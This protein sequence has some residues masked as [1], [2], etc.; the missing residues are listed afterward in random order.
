MRGIGAIAD[1]IVVSFP[2][3]SRSLKVPRP[4]SVVTPILAAILLCVTPVSGAAANAYLP[5][6]HEL[7]QGV[8]GQ[9]ISAY[10]Q[11]TGKHPAI[12]QV[13]SAWG[14]WLPAIFADAHAA[15]ARLMIHMTSASGSSEVITPGQI[16]RGDG[17]GWL[18]ALNQEIAATHTITYVRWMAEMDAYWNPYS[19]FNADGS[20]RDADHSTAAYRAA[21]RRAAL[22]LRG[23]ALTS[24]N[25]SLRAL[26]QPAVRG[27]HA[28]LPVAPV[29]MVWCPQVAGA[30]D[31][32]GN[33][34]SDYFPGRRWVDWMG[35]DFYSKF[36][37][38]TGLTRFYTAFRGLPFAFGEWSMWGA[39]NP[40]FVDQ[41]FRWVGAHSRVRMLVYNQGWGGEPFE[42]RLYP[43]AAA[44][45]RAWLWGGRW[46]GFV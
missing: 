28:A 4:A 5:P 3:L 38:F 36:P 39:D 19:A 40:G 35:T 37:N 27:V 13:F 22:I 33:E 7:F 23:G 1:A 26:G 10:Q 24:I 21:W 34:P 42:L 8:T 18:V 45:I 2:L 41:F 29:A 9:P 16:A 17:D 12:Y 30:P 14:Q 15:N 31:V 25:G 6:A 11:A 46:P 44:R 20:R 32:A 43:R